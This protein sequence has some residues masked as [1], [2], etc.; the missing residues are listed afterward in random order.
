MTDSMHEDISDA[1]GRDLGL[2]GALNAR[3][4]GGLRAG[5]GKVVRRGQVFRMDSP[6]FLTVADRT[7]LVDEMGLKTVVDL[8]YERESAEEGIGPLA[9]TAVNHI[10]IPIRSSERQTAP[11][12]RQ[13]VEAAHGR[14]VWEVT[15]EYYQGYF[16]AGKGAAIAEAVRALAEPGALPAIVNCAAGKDRTGAV[17]AVTL[18]AIGVPD[19]LVADDYGASAPNVPGIIGRLHSL[20]TYIDIDETT[21]DLQTPRSQTMRAVLEWLRE[22]YGGIDEYLLASGLTQDD[23]DRLRAALLEN[24]TG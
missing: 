21:V 13:M 8:R 10:N 19:E 18:A 14:P 24:A 11:G 1:A 15:F 2:E 16:T 3:D 7:A 12:L 6:Q 4:I 20:G 5:D 9:D 23:L 17:I 22:E